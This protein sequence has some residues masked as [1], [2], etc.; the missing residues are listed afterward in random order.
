MDDKEL[1][2]LFGF[3]EIT[4]IKA[5][6]VTYNLYQQ[7]GV[8]GLRGLANFNVDSMKWGQSHSRAHFAMLKCLLTEGGGCIV[9]HHDAASQ[10]LRVKVD[11]SK[12]ISHGKPALGQMLLRL[13]VYR[14]IADVQAC[15]EYYE[16]L[17]SVDREYLSWRE[18]VLA[19]KPPAMLNVQANTFLKD[20]EVVLKQYAASVQGIIESWVD[21]NV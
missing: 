21:R 6:D 7:L 10:T 14:C 13:H 9:I 11:K 12:I 2:V 17:S 18:T 19:N 4:E 20:G 1:M 8:D 3:T 15:R 16:D 5:S